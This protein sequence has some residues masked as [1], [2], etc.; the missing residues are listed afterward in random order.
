MIC[1][2]EVKNAFG[3]V[4]DPVNGIGVS[5]VRLSD[6]IVTGRQKVDVSE[7]KRVKASWS[8]EDTEG[9]LVPGSMSMGSQAVY[10]CSVMTAPHT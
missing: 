10:C 3:S 5:G 9:L 2:R 7:V 4:G 6:V 8:S 1:G